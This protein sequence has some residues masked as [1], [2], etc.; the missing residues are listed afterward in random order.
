MTDKTSGELIEEVQAF[1]SGRVGNLVDYSDVVRRV[2]DNLDILQSRI[3]KL[4]QEVQRRLT[5]LEAS[6]IRSDMRQASKII[7]EQQD[8]INELERRC[9]EQQARIAYLEREY[10]KRSA[11]MQILF[12]AVKS[13]D[14][15]ERLDEFEEW[16]DSD[17]VP[18]QTGA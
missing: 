13:R 18:K 17:G 8:N 15:T 10:V 4:E 11:R 2:R 7:S 3:A 12:E 5:P 1:V 9:Q 16:F 6:N 14:P